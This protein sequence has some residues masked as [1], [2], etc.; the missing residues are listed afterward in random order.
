MCQHVEQTLRVA[1]APLIVVL[2]PQGENMQGT[3]TS[4]EVPQEVTSL[5]AMTPVFASSGLVS[6]G[7][8][9]N[10]KLAARAVSPTTSTKHARPLVGQGD[11]HETCIGADGFTLRIHIDDELP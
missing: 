6:R 7:Y 9:S 11:M 4:V 10:E 3:E 5:K 1:Y 8:P 2:A